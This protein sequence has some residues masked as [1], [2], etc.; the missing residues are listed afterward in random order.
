MLV[1]KGARGKSRIVQLLA[2]A[3]S[4]LVT[5]KA[6]LPDTMTGIVIYKV[7]D[8]GDIDAGM[9]LDYLRRYHIHMVIFYV[10]CRE[11]EIGYYQKLS[12]MLEP[13]IQCLITVQN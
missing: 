1:L 4:T 6:G 11:E 8:F 9:L 12:E 5:D 2:R 3:C 7:K 10:N 13:H